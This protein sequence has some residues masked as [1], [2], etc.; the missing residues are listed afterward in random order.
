MRMY[1]KARTQGIRDLFQT[2]TCFCSIK[3]WERA[4]LSVDGSGHVPTSRC[5]Q[6]A[7]FKYDF[8]RCVACSALH[9][10]RQVFIIGGEYLSDL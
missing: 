1:A 3:W 5:V 7:R 10:A 9:F 8:S 4:D 2:V 6:F